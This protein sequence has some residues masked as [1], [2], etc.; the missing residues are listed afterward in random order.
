MT[1]ALTSR[2]I[3]ATSRRVA[4]GVDRRVRPGHSILEAGRLLPAQACDRGPQPLGGPGMRL[5]DL[6]ALEELA[7]RDHRAEADAHRRQARA[8]PARRERVVGALDED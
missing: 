3:L 5:L 7:R 2:A 8:P 6:I 4:S 1:P